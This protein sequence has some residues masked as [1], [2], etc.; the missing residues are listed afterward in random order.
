M[1]SSTPTELL[2]RSTYLIHDFPADEEHQAEVISGLANANVGGM[3]LT[4]RK[5]YNELS[6][7]WVE[8]CEELD[9]RV[10]A[11]IST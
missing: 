1:L 3:L 2:A 8:F 9:G 6:E 5:S 4:T 11:W 10:G 7:L